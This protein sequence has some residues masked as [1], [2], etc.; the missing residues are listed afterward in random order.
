MGQMKILAERKVTMVELDINVDNKTLNIFA[1]A[2]LREIK[3]DKS[4][5]FNY[6][7]VNALRRGLKK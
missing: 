3:K 5:L 7:F 4:A 1:K 6:A 2:G